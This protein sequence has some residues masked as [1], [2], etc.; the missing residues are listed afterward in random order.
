MNSIKPEI[1][2]EN[3]Y[4]RKPENQKRRIP[5]NLKSG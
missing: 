4:S 3:R 1:K 2:E 5:E